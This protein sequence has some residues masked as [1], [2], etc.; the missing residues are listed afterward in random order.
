VSR[1]EPIRS[2]LARPWR[3]TGEQIF[4]D[5]AAL[6]TPDVDGS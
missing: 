5:R 4:I 1:I 6:A 3:F 2:R